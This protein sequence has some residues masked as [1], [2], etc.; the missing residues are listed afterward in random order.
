MRVRRPCRAIP[1]LLLAIL[2]SPAFAWRGFEWTEWQSISGESAP[3]ALPA[4]APQA[5]MPAPRPPLIADDPSTPIETIGDWETKRD[6]ILGTLGALLGATTDD[7]PVPAYAEP[8]GVTREQG[9]DRRHLR[10]AAGHDDW[11][12]AWL[13]VPHNLPAAGAPVMLV[14]H[15]TVPQGKDEPVGINGSDDIDFA[16]ELVARG[17]VCL[18]P[19]M[20]GFGERIGPGGQP[21]DGALD[22]YRRHPQWSYFGKM[23]AD[24][25]RCIDYLETLPFAD[26]RRLGII[27]HSHGAYTSLMAAAHDPRI[28]AVIAS[29]GF[30]LLRD[31]PAPNRWSHAT[32]L[33]PRLGFYLDDIKQAPFDWHEIVATIAPR[34]AFVRAT[35]DDDIFPNT[36]PIEKLRPDFTALWGLYGNAGRFELRLDPGPHNFPEAKRNEAY[37]WL[38]RV[39]PPSSP[40]AALRLDPPATAAEWQA[41][42]ESVKSLIL[43]DIGPIDPP[44]LAADWREIE[45]TPREDY[46][47]KLIEYD[48]AERE[49]IRARLLIPAGDA[50]TRPAILVFHQTSPEG[51]DEPAGHIGR[52]SM[53]FAPALARRGYI[54]L[55]PDSIAAGERIRRGGAFDTRGFYADA[56]DGSALGRMIRD[57]RRALTILQSVPGVDG[58]RIGTIGHSLGAEESLFV[59]AFD[60]RV[61]AAVASCGFAPF[62]A[63]ANVERWARPQWF[64]YMPRLRPELRAGRLPA[65]DFDAVAMLVAPRAYFHF[66]TT[67]DEIFPEGEASIPQIE[68]TRHLWRLEDADDRLITRSE[69]GRHDVSPE[70]FEA[71][72][73]FFDAN[74]K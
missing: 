5:G 60:D 23:N 9:Y 49:K 12:T 51:K 16:R 21:Y 33:M 47:E 27:G 56:P 38:D 19:D 41:R 67:D 63:E 11:I 22:F 62:A 34:P 3:P 28:G 7:C 25:S 39:L 40:L 2:P 43:H 32:A 4:P 53:H 42:R 50:A 29:C 30:N 15:Q 54:V 10:I 59:A 71:M 13:L 66:Q 65:W 36:A 26:M 6:R 18:V 69:P 35:L 70:A 14:I 57:G 68:S 55:C 20:I 1:L 74:L 24:I 61:K 45:S 72:L 48:V 73:S 64:S 8:L 52:P 46:V 58:D 31:D 37:D 44:A 17:Y